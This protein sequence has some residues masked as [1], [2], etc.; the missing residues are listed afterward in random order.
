MVD[1]HS[2][3]SASKLTRIDVIIGVFPL[4][5]SPFGHHIAKCVPSV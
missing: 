5:V 4:K 2:K 3:S 1:F